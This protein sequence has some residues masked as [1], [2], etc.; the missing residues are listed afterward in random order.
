M[1]PLAT[2]LA[3][4]LLFFGP[5]VYSQ[6]FGAGAILGLN[7]SQIDGDNQFGYRK[8]G[9][10]GGLRGIAHLSARFDLQVEMLYSLR[11]S[12]AKTR[13]YKGPATP[14]DIKLQYAEAP[15]LLNYKV[16]ENWDGQYVLH[17]CTGFSYARLLGSEVK[18]RRS[19]PTNQEDFNILEAEKDFKRNEIG[20]VLGAAFLPIPKLSVELRHV[21]ALNPLF[22][23][24]MHD[25]RTLRSYYLQLQV[26]YLL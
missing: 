14:V 16:L 10:A 4:C 11:G 17:F 7:A 23:S 21:F 22:K 18:E 6:R 9:L 19:T 20:W 12:A 25:G 13:G 15:L 26:A 8:F 2:L 3:L 1:K 24:D 5:S